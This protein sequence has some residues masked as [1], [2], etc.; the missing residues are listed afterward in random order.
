MAADAHELDEHAAAVVLVERCG[1]RAD[2]L[3]MWLVQLQLA[4][5]SSLPGQAIYAG[6]PRALRAAELIRELAQLLE[7]RIIVL[8]PDPNAVTRPLG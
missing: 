3:R 6:S 5:A 7:L 1:E 8:E 4:L 2:E